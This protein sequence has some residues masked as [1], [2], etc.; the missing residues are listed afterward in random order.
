[1]LDEALFELDPVN[2]HPL[3]NDATTAIS[4]ADMLKFIRAQGREPIR[5]SFDAQ[6]LP[7]RIE[8]DAPPA[9]L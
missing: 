7:T 8:P 9:H 6:G 2:F 4:P 1:M 3:K 5:L